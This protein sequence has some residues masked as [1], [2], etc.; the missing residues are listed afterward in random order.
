MEGEKGM[1]VDRQGTD[2][3]AGDEV[4]RGK[5]YDKRRRGRIGKRRRNEA[6]SEWRGGKRTGNGKTVNGKKGAQCRIIMKV[7]NEGDCIQ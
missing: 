7:R 1:G 2:D 4:G 3:D 6:V 5:R